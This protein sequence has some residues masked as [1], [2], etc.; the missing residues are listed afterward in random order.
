MLKEWPLVAF[1]ILGQTAVGLF[2]FFHLPFLVRGRVPAYGWRVTGLAVLGAVALL[3]LLAAGLSF[4]H[5][6]HPFRAR[7]ALGNLRTSWLSREILFELVFT[8]LVAVSVWLGALHNPG[9]RLQWALLVVAGLAGGLFLLSM[10]KLYMLPALPVWR[11]TYTPLAFLSTTLAVGAVSTDVL[12]RAVAG[13]GVFAVDLAAV[14]LVVLAGEILLAALA[15]PRHGRRGFRPAPSL[16]PDDAPPR[17]LHRARL[18]FLFAGM[19]LVAIDKLS[20][21]NTI[22][23]ERGTS[24][25]L[26]LALLLLLAGEAAGRFHYY[27]LVPRPG[28][29]DLRP[30]KA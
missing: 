30:F 25:A 13:P 6:R 27:G 14:A 17:L 22:M 4:F 12:V 28:G 23:A 10:I 7:R 24:P 18:W 16:R 5:L 11:R 2:W 21:A 8:A 26:L 9:L 29:P 19:V 3:M 15:A 1:T 20:G